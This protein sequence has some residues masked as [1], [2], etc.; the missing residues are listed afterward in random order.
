VKWVALVAAIGCAGRT[1]EI[2][3]DPGDLSEATSAPRIHAIV[4]LGGADVLLTGDLI[5]PPGDGVAAV[6]EALW[7]RGSSF[8]RRPTVTIAGR[9]AAVLARTTDGGLVVRVPPGAAVGTQALTVANDN[10]HS[11]FVLTVRRLVATLSPRSGRLAWVDLSADGPRASGDV[12]ATGQYLRVGSDGRAAYVLDGTTAKLTVFELAAQ[13]TPRAIFEMDL[14]ARDGLDPVIAF[15]ASTQ[16]SALMVLR[17]HEILVLDTSAALHP[18][19]SQARSLPPS[20]QKAGIV[21]AALSPD[22]HS[23]AVALDEGNRVAL[24]DLRQ[25]GIASLGS[26]LGLA[27]E[28]RVPVLVD[29]AFAPDGRTV[30]VALG[31]TPKSRQIGPRPTEIVALRI[32]PTTGALSIA[33]RVSID[34]A[35]G[36]LRLNTGRAIPL[37]SG[38]SV[39]LPPERATVYLTASGHAGTATV[40]RLGAD[41]HATPF[42]EVL[43][44]AGAAELTWDGRWLLV[45][46]LLTTGRLAMMAAPADDR[47]G[48]RHLV[49][50]G[51]APLRVGATG[52]SAAERSF[53]SLAAQP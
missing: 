30:W 39:R 40:F 6:G 22:G 48:E 46:V 12:A 21:A 45:P 53:P 38:S 4:E 15:A 33:R 36:P 35:E 47:P 44:R 42:V 32:D 31:D 9:P 17:S 16:A 2:V 43:G 23:V 50:L 10:G 1:G 37:A 18:V 41:D 8:G 29:V 5:A 34:E 28:S 27:P 49:D 19:R 51:A 26:E 52:E 14:G 13:G 3:T 11:D 20:V 7:V 25:P 24:I